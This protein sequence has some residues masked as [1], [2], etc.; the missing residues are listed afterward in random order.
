[1][2]KITVSILFFVF[3][4][5]M[6]SDA[7]TI[8]DYIIE[9]RGDTLVVKDYQLTQS[10]HTLS[11]LVEIDTLAPS[12][13]VY[14]LISGGWYL[15]T[16]RVKVANNRPLRII[17]EDDTPHV[18]SKSEKRPPIVA[19]MQIG[20]MGC[21]G[22]FFELRSNTTIKNIMGG[23][24][25]T[26]ATIGL[27][28][29]EADASGISLT[30][31]N[32]YLEHTR[33]G[34]I[35]MY[36]HDNNSLFIRNSYFVNMGGNG[37]RRHG[38]VYNYGPVSAASSIDTLWVENSTHIMG[39]GVLY[40]LGRYPINKL[41]FNHNTFVNI[42]NS[43]FSTLG[44]HTN[45]LVT[46]NLFI[47]TNAQ[48]YY[49]GMDYEDSDQDRYPMGIVNMDT[50][51]GT[52]NAVNPELLPPDFQH[53]D[54][55]D[56]ES[57]RKVLVHLN[58]VYWS[59]ELDDI[60]ENIKTTHAAYLDTL[61][62]GSVKDDLMLQMMT[63]NSR[64]QHMFDN[65]SVWPNLIEGVWYT[66][67]PPG[68]INDLGLLDESAALGD[69]MDYT[70]AT[71]ASSPPDPEGNDNPLP[72]EDL[73]T[74]ENPSYN[75]Y[76]VLSDWPVPV[77]LS[78]TNAYYLTGGLNG[79]PVG[80]LNW[81]PEQKE[82]WLQQRDEEYETLENYDPGGLSITK[83]G[84]IPTAIELHQNYPNPFNPSTV[85]S[86]Q[87]AE[88]SEVQLKVYDIAGREVADLVSGRKTAGRHS[89]SF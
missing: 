3:F 50:L 80:D 7:Q 71:F 59:P 48:V 43:V 21:S 35:H 68:F 84:N 4:G 85:I 62:E 54:P 58:G 81:F 40:N 56:W 28:F 47:N 22:S 44:Y 89:V 32:V 8:E 26:D 16:F 23:A 46:N 33:L 79:F 82:N 70:I 45:W 83:D 34:F 6:S 57:M 17:G 77:N 69:F 61:Q 74:E 19:G 9:Q 38:G 76:T 31:D 51:N 73:R 66:Q 18:V 60:V 25:C 75:E 78:Y 39:G 55:E 49:P 14:E 15:T 52:N 24:R 41:V 13:R 65:N 10:P 88:N 5:M 29:I 64:T 30:L 53:A 63:M 72:L 27:S 86:Y 37:Y 1:M 42:S 2:P 67:G 12:S 36:W 11:E 20:D 87:L